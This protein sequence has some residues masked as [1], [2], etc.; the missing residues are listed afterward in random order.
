MPNTS[1]QLTTSRPAQQT[2][3]M[4]LKQCSGNAA[5]NE[6]SK[7]EQSLTVKDSI[8]YGELIVSQ[9]SKVE[10]IREIIKIV[11][12]Y[13]EVTGKKLEVY[14]TRTLA[15]DLYD[16]FKTDTVEDLILMF[17]MIRTGDLGKPPYTD[18]FHE[19][20]MSYVPLFLDFKSR[21]RE[22]LIELK[23]RKIKAQERPPEPQTMSE[24]AY[25]KFTE[26]QSR[27]S[28]P[29]N[30]NKQIFSIKS[31]LASVDNYIENL[32]E[33]CKKLSAKDLNYEIIRTQY[34]NKT[35]YNI[36]LE[37]QQRRKDEKKKNKRC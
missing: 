19:K 5:F 15:G 6:I 34:N 30:K 25:Q 32:P 1:K 11:E 3:L 20:I 7:L 33:T 22:R 17:K 26:L 24:E 21:E 29:V 36:L 2:T 31:V 13:L 28:N 12:F 10:V 16:K 8:K 9:G 18:N 23:K 27:L 14:Q 37:E 4:I 35:A